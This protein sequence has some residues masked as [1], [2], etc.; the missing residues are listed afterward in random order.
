MPVANVLEAA[1]A[2]IT[3]VGAVRALAS[4]RLRGAGRSKREVHDVAKTIALGVVLA[5]APAARA[6]AAEAATQPGIDA[7]QHEAVVAA[8]EAELDAVG[9]T[10][11]FDERRFA[12][13]DDTASAVLPQ[14]GPRSA[15]EAELDGLTAA[16]MAENAV[17]GPVVAAPVWG[18]DIASDV[19]AAEAEL[20]ALLASPA[21]QQRANSR[22]TTRAADVLASDAHDDSGLSPGGAF[23]PDLGR[24][25]TDRDTDPDT[26]SAQGSDAGAT[27]DC[28]CS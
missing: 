17:H 24:R 23:D 14:D 21:E 10:L 7:P 12:R 5:F 11:K 6:K 20:H 3:V 1:V 15:A 13:P 22:S 4:A 8:P 27:D 25:P 28:S 16:T 9:D 19:P 2:F 18:D 26:A